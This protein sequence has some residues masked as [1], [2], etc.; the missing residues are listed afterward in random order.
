M[1][2]TPRTIPTTHSWRPEIIDPTTPQGRERLVQLSHLPGTLITDPII[3]QVDD[4]LLSRAPTLNPT[5]LACA[6]HQLMGCDDDSPDRDDFGR[7]VH[8]PWSR[9]LVHILPPEQ[10]REA[11]LARNQLKITA[12]EQAILTRRTVAIIG[13]SVG[14]QIAVTLAMEGVCG[15]FRLA[16][17]DTLSLSNMNRLPAS[18]SELGLSKVVLAARQLHEIDPYLDIEIALA[19][20]N[21]DNLDGFLG[22][23]PGAGMDSDGQVVDLVIEECDDIALKVSLR[24]RLRQLGVPVLME[25]SERGTLD[26][27]RYDLEPDRPLLHGL[28]EDVDLDGLQAANQQGERKA[29]RKLIL[30]ILPAMR[31]RTWESVDR[32]GST[33]R[34]WPQLASEIALGAA[35]VTT[36]ARRILL[37][38][39]LASGRHHVDLDLLL[40]EN[41]LHSADPSG[42]ENRP[43]GPRLDKL[44]SRPMQ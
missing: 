7:W 40:A 15:G 8:Y 18:V 25:T 12:A 1:T 36:A 17:G 4:L 16:D 10:F 26:I 43:I 33:L 30:S 35:T 14:R 42:L 11:R 44:S 22:V 38:G 28:L 29:A 5:E 20:L 31:P 41:R 37:G 32:V 19:G 9:F 27:E 3:A 34:S 2:S 23:A 39:D 21:G 24:R 6:R 13:L